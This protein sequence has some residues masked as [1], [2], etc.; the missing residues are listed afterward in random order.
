MI[1]DE[2][3][4]KRE[5]IRIILQETKSYYDKIQELR[6]YINQLEER[7]KCLEAKARI[8]F[9]SEEKIDEYLHEGYDRAKDGE[10][11]E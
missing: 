11:K 6:S 10:V 4:F 5:M 9:I 1:L 7:I 8:D 2:K 3:E